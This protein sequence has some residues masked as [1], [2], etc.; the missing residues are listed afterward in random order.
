MKRAEEKNSRRSAVSELA[1]GEKV[2]ME[3]RPDITA[4]CVPIAL[5]VIFFVFPITLMWYA[6]G[7]YVHLAILVMAL[8]SLGFLGALAYINYFHTYYLVTNRR[9]ISQT[10]ILSKEHKECRLDRIHNINVRA[11]LYERLLGVGNVV[12]SMTE[13]SPTDV[14]FELIRNPMKVRHKIADLLGL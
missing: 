9:A 12:F 2:L 11:S 5:S 1:R 8:L 7:G 3:L 10:G 13:E 4:M 14:S 6:I